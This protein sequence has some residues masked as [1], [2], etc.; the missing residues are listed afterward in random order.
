[1]LFPNDYSKL[2]Y[3]PPPDPDRELIIV[4]KSVW[5]VVSEEKDFIEGGF[6]IAT[7]FVDVAPDAYCVDDMACRYLVTR[8]EGLLIEWSVKL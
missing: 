8:L 5:D 3:P 6:P 4:P 1:M 2:I 7:F